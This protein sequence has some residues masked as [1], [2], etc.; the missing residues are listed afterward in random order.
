MIFFC[1]KV[2]YKVV[3]V[4]LK[5]RWTYIKIIPIP[6]KFMM[7]YEKC[8]Q[9]SNPFLLIKLMNTTKN[10]LMTFCSYFSSKY[11][12]TYL[13][14]LTHNQLFEMLVFFYFHILIENN[15]VLFVVSDQILKLMSIY[16]NTINKTNRTNRK[17]KT[18]YDI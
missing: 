18:C 8:F 5:V 7:N 10:I 17:N 6:N 3:F 14:I 16:H 2:I 1:S 9:N 4:R 12:S 13:T 11:L 15:H